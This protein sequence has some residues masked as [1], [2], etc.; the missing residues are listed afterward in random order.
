MTRK[1]LSRLLL[2]AGALLLAGCSAVS[3]LPNQ[4]GEY[5]IK[6]KSIGYDGR[7]YSFYWV[8]K[9]NTLKLARRDNVK[10]MQDERSYLEM[11][12]SEPI[13]H[14]ASD[15]P[16][17]VQ[18]EDQQGGFSSFWFPFMM[19]QMMAGRGPVIINQPYPGSPQTPSNQPTYHYPPTS[20]FGR[21]DTL[22]GSVTNNKPSAPD[23]SKMAPA[24]YAVSGQSGGT[25]SGTAASNKQGSISGQSG[26]TGSGSAA[27]QK[28][29]FKSGSSSYSSKSGVAPHVGGG[30]G[31]SSGSRGKAPS[32]S[33]SRSIGG[34][35]GGG[36]RGGGK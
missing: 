6:P 26:G 36:G 24:P 3:T 35:S 1:T 9:D 18:A 31:L 8:D 32:T 28:G 27:S 14:L 16:V 23:Y 34:R 33:G 11:R 22:Q 12:G 20:T 10:M 21:D 29:G 4:P 25:G 17:T 30:S 13:L 2:I 7:E 5:Q 19:G 15:E